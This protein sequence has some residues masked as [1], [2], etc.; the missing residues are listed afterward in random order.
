MDRRE[1]YEDPEEMLR[2]A[3]Q[4]MQADLWTAIPGR[5]VAF[6]GNTVSVQPT[7]RRRVRGP[8]GTFTPRD[9]PVLQ[10]VPVQ[11]PGGGGGTLTFPVA[12]GDECLVVFSSRGIDHWWQNSGVQEP[13]TP[14]MHDL[15]DGFAL[16]G[17]R[18]KPRALS[19]VSTSTVQLRADDG[20]TLVELDP[21]GQVVRIVAPGKVRLETPL[22]E[23]TGDVK[24]GTVSLQ[25]HKHSGV[26]AGGAQ[27]GVPVP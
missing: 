20:G 8:D 2:A 16:L 11:F 6:Q 7:I 10:D 9:L 5:I 14:R 25:S 26:Q 22:L 15:S 18:S 23:V 19:G 12:V 1:R 21:A 27:T 17:F 4:A 13:A 3:Q 24:A